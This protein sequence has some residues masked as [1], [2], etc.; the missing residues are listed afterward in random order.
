MSLWS[1]LQCLFSLTTPVCICTVSFS[2]SY[3]WCSVY[4][5]YFLI[6]N[7]VYSTRKL[8][9]RKKKLQYRGLVR[10]AL[11]KDTWINQNGPL[12]P[13]LWFGGSLDLQLESGPLYIQYGRNV[14]LAKR[15]NWLFQAAANRLIS[16]FV[17]GTRTLKI[18]VFGAVFPYASSSG[19][20]AIE[21]NFLNRWVGRAEE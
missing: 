18:V 5:G 17:S 4:V 9:Y 10:T 14:I 7:A 15:L 16:S 8:R 11:L 3:S 2:G 20:C 13:G 6:S 19:K 1:N 21:Y 12:F